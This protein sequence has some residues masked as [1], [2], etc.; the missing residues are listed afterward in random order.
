MKHKLLHLTIALAAGMKQFVYAVGSEQLWKGLLAVVLEELGVNLARKAH[1]LQSLG[2]FCGNENS[3]DFLDDI[4]SQVFA[5]I[6]REIGLRSQ[7]LLLFSFL[8]LLFNRL[9]QRIII[10]RIIFSNF[11]FCLHLSWQMDHISILLILKVWR[12]VP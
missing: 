11:S 10:L 5:I 3:K 12:T 8:L 6:F 2:V 1:Q 4:T 9:R 7:F